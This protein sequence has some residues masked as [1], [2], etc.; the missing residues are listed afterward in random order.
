MA[1]PECYR[2]SLYL[3]WMYEGFC[4]RCSHEWPVIGAT[5]DFWRS[6]QEAA[7]TCVYEQ[8]VTYCNA[9][10]YDL[11]DCR[12]PTTCQ[13]LDSAFACCQQGAFPG[14]FHCR[15]RVGR[16]CRGSYPGQ[17]PHYP[18]SGI[19][20][21]GARCERDWHDQLV[22]D[23]DTDADCVRMDC[24]SCPGEFHESLVYA[25]CCLCRDVIGGDFCR[26]Y[27]GNLFSEMESWE[28]D[29][30]FRAGPQKEGLGFQPCRT[31]ETRPPCPT[32]TVACCRQNECI[33]VAANTTCCNQPGDQYMGTGT[34]CETH[35]TGTP[36][37][38]PET[39]PLCVPD[40]CGKPS[41]RCCLCNWC[42]DIP[43]TRCDELGGFYDPSG[44]YLFCESGAGEDCTGEKIKPRCERA[45]WKPFLRDA[46][47][48][49]ISTRQVAMW[50]A[51]PVFKFQRGRVGRT[52]LKHKGIVCGMY[53]RQKV[54]EE[55][56][57]V[58]VC[59]VLTQNGSLDLVKMGYS[60]FGCGYRCV[61]PEP[62]C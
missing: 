16:C 6:A 30:R 19:A 42:C 14:V 48:L 39:D 61:C 23:P 47:H 50:D 12:P 46:Y 18:W 44:P 33:D 1:C 41:P 24:D 62:P 51:D 28:E 5:G 22:C 27:G 49:L 31:C 9:H 25:S 58:N 29:C 35:W 2:H 17:E 11:E 8:K 53:D 13:P 4:C 26:E 56:E 36:V 45:L 40:K 60:V 54:I 55:T 43:K 7:S 57:E 34:R 21:E 32:E 10:G 52:G 3:I 59:R 15:T 38:D 37:C 20:I